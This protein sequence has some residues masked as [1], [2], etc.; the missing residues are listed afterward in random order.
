MN[1]KILKTLLDGEFLPVVSPVAADGSGAALNCNADDAACAVAE[2]LGAD[3]LLFLTDTDGILVDARNRDTRI[4]RMGV[5]RVQELIEGGFADGG[6]LPKLKSCVHAVTHGVG[7]VVILDGRVEHSSC[8]KAFPRPAW[9]RSSRR[10]RNNS[11]KGPLCRAKRPL[12]CGG[13]ARFKEI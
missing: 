1:P 10:T 5:R 7:R 4:A 11:K 2:A 6:M 9:A 3:K 8:W 13:G 12:F